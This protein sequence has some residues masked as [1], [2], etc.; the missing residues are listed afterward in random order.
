M[1]QWWEALTGFQQAMFVVA[2]IATAIMTIFLILMLFGIEGGEASAFG[3]DLDAGGVD[4]DGDGIPDVVDMPGVDEINHEPV[5][6]IGNLKL[7]TVRSVLAFLAVG[8]W[9]AFSLGESIHPLL[10]ALVGAVAGFVAAFLLAWAIRAAYRLENEGNVDYRN[11]V[12]KNASVYIRI[13]K[14]RSGSGKVN[15]LVQERLDPSLFLAT[16]P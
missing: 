6:V 10:A 13:P 9:T 2:A 16:L 7:L 1:S 5:T 14:A 3:G 8:G 12:G 4:L 15:V 11:A